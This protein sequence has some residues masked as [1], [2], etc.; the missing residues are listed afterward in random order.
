MEVFMRGQHS[1]D[2]QSEQ[3]VG[4]QEE[5]GSGDRLREHPDEV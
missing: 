2:R 5:A 3:E 4:S 1:K